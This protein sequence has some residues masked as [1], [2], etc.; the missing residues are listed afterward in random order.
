MLLEKL[1]RLSQA[2]LVTMFF[3]ACL[4]LTDTRRRKG[5]WGGAGTK[6]APAKPHLVKKVAGIDPKTRA[7]HGKAN[8]IIS[9]RRD[10]KAEKYAVRDL[11]YPYT[12]KAQYDDLMSAAL[13]VEWNT[14][15]S[16]Q[17]GTLPRVVKKVNTLAAQE[18]GSLLLTS[19]R[20][21]MGTV[22][23]PLEKL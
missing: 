11:P 23:E 15:L 14:R 21:Q 5:S 2:G 19:L 4:L 3:F 1:T 10:K 22:I 6:K 7:D 17:R 18:F 16:F 13:G 20:L 8:V 9:E 12:S